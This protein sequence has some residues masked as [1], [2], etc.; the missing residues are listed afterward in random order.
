MEDISKMKAGISVM[1]MNQFCNPVT[2]ITIACDACSYSPEVFG[3][4]TSFIKSLEFLHYYQ[5]CDLWEKLW[6]E[7]YR[8]I[9]PE[10]IQTKNDVIS[11]LYP[12]CKTTMSKIY[13]EL[14]C[15]DLSFKVIYF[16]LIAGC[17]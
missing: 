14:K 15:G 6:V 3:T 10:E 12:Q 5:G 2:P 7:E 13:E 16:R 17:N 11:K 1:R 4:H 8:T 9:D